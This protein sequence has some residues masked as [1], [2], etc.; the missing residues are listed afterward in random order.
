MIRPGKQHSS[1]QKRTGGVN[2][3]FEALRE[4][5]Q[6][7][8]DETT[9]SRT[10]QTSASLRPYYRLSTSFNFRPICETEGLQCVGFSYK[11]TVAS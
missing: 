6:T 9:R 4:L 3:L 7:V 8:I 5:Y 10:T 2:E 11:V 1:D